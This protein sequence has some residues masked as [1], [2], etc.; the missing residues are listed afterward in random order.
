MLIVLLVTFSLIGYF[1]GTQASGDIT[2]TQEL[3]P[4]WVAA[5]ATVSIALLTIF[6]AKE[7]WELRQ[8]QLL[9]IDQ[10]R[11]DSIKPSI[12]FFIKSSPAAY[13]FMDV[14]VRNSGTGPATNIQFRF[15]RKDES[16]KEVFEYLQEEF[17]KLAIIKNGIASLAP[18][19]TRTSYVFSFLD[20][21]GK[22]KDKWFN[23]DIDIDISF[24]DIEGTD[25]QSTSTIYLSEYK[26]VSELGGGD[27]IHKI[28]SIL[29]KIERNFSHLTTGFRKIKTDVYTSEDRR[30]E[31]EE[32]E[33]ERAARKEKSAANKQINEGQD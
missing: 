21:G 6:L 25:Y 32:W 27:P 30:I 22:F 5:L 18:E 2:L 13:Q 29:E 14:F 24:K 4:A 8:I 33:A 9:Q 11:R 7:T 10:I 19:E 16:D 3:L 26:G 31:A 28:S 1:F 15:R 23:C 17:T 12:N 20:L